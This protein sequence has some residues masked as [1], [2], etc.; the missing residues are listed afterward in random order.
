MKISIDD[1]FISV[2]DGAQILGLSLSTFYSY[3]WRG[4]IK[5]YPNQTKQMIKKD[6]LMELQ[7]KMKK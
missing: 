2:K 7:K 3:I 4:F 1:E 6:D 5:S